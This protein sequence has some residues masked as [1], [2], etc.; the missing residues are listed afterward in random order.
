MDNP[1][2]FPNKGA[3]ERVYKTPCTSIWI[4]ALL[5]IQGYL[6]NVARVFYNNINPKKALFTLITDFL[7]TFHVTLN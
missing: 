1:L 6:K 4:G 2:I 3:R 7:G 5:M